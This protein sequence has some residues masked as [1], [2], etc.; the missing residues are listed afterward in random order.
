MLSVEWTADQGW[1][2]PR[3]IPF[4]NLSLNPA[5]C[6][7]H[8]AFEC[9]EGMKAYK[10]DKGVVR[11]FRPDMNMKRLNKSTSRI[12]LPTLDGEALIDLLKDLVRL[13]N[14]FIPE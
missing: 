1:H 6:V 5:T 8:Y 4:Q 7:F 3:I 14:R 9:F 2:A 11:L 13:E 10:D 12:A